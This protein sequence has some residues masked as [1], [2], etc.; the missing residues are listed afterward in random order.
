MWPALLFCSSA[1]GLALG[2]A[3]LKVWPLIPGT[4]IFA[5]I[6]G[7][8]GVMSGLHWG[9]TA[10]MV[11]ATAAIL[12]FSYVIAGLLYCRTSVRSR[13]PEP[14]CGPSRELTTGSNSRSP[15]RNWRGATNSI[16][17]AACHAKSTS[18][19]NEAIGNSI[20]IKTMKPELIILTVITL[21]MGSV[22]TIMH[23]AC[24]SGDRS[25]CASTFTARHHTK[26]Q[27][28]A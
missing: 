9:S 5:L 24:K 15:V 1:S 19:P 8:S 23:E 6:A 3:R 20:R 12:Q 22:L 26:N 4:I 11:F 2:L 27:P 7:V 17:D 28:P 21:I 14:P 25:W 13:S 10:V 18:N 16:S